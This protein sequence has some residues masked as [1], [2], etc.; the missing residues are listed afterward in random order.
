M[1]VVICG[2]RCPHDIPFAHRAVYWPAKRQ[3]DGVWYHCV[4][5]YIICAY[6]GHWIEN[7]MPNCRCIASCHSEARSGHGEGFIITMGD[8]VE[9]Q[10]DNDSPETGTA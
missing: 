1:T 4:L 6:C 8:P 10:N 2:K 3:S 7:R 9:S 5:T